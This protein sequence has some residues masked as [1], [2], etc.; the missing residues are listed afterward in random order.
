MLDLAGVEFPWRNTF[1]LMFTSKVPVEYM[2]E[3]KLDYKGMRVCSHIIMMIL[4][5]LIND[6][7]LLFFEYKYLI[8]TMHKN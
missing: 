5:P 7:L 3:R 1:Q 6:N 2:R 8:E 4:Y